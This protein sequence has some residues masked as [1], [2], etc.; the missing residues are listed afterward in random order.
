MKWSRLFCIFCV[1]LYLCVSLSFTAS[2]VLDETSS[3]D[4]PVIID[5]DLDSGNE[6]EASFDYYEFEDVVEPEDNPIAD[7]LNSGEPIPVVVLEPETSFSVRAGSAGEPLLIIGDEPPA[8]PV[9]YGSGWITGTD[10]NL[11]SVTLY[12]PANYKTG[13]WGTDRNG[14]LYNISS[15]SISG[16]LDGVYNNSVA[17]SAFS[18]PRYRLDSGTGY[19]YENLYLTPENSNMEIAVSNSPKY[20]I[21][22]FE[23]YILL[24]IGGVL[25]LCYMKRS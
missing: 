20:D 10:P 15:S 2:A 7:L 9:F 11:G 23:P 16:Y 25:V 18:Y 8:N 3:V 17:A 14:Y 24:F 12:F 13:H 1:V 22:T 5:T 4:E 21:K 19:N 6:N